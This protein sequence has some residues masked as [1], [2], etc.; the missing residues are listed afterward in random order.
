MK[1]NKNN[2]FQV[3]GLQ[4][5]HRQPSHSL[6]VRRNLMFASIYST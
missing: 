1:C 5:A 4:G 3:H 2:F 6:R